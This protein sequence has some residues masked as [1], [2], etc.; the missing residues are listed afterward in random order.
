MRIS[1]QRSRSSVAR[2]ALMMGEAPA[3]RCGAL[4]AWNVHFLRIISVVLHRCRA[5]RISPDPRGGGEY[6]AGR[7]AQLLRG[8]S[9]HPAQSARFSTAASGDTSAGFRGG[10]QLVRRAHRPARAPPGVITSLHTR[11]CLY[12]PPPL[13]GSRVAAARPRGGGSRGAA[14][15]ADLPKPRRSLAH[16]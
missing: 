13:S 15:L 2:V 3:F 11:A 9:G 8:I 7:R 6:L 4:P 12:A 16:A 14:T 1:W 5:R 10:A